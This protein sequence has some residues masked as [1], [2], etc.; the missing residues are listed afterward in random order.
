M[1]PLSSEHKRKISQSLIKYHSSCKAKKP[2]SEIQKEILRLQ[3]RADRD[4][5]NK[6]KEKLRKEIIKL[7]K[8]INK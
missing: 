3:K 5:L 1:P 6:D 8:M 2:K 4:I 7:K